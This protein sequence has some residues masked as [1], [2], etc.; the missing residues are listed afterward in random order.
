MDDFGLRRRLA[1]GASAARSRQSDWETAA[2]R[3]DEVLRWAE[4]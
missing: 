4:T 2:R 3:M 1:R